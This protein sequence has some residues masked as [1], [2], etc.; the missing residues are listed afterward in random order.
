[1]YKDNI[2]CD[3]WSNREAYVKHFK[4][5]ISKIIHD[6]KIRQESSG[7]E[8]IDRRKVSSSVIKQESIIKVVT[9]VE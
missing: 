7:R 4:H 5:D 3:V 1:M 8:L 6:L 9:T 2:I